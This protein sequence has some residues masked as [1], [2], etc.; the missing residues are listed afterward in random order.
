ML[1][2]LLSTGTIFNSHTNKSN[3]AYT[4]NFYYYLTN[5]IN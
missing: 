5:E 4:N 1:T 3:Y 2:H